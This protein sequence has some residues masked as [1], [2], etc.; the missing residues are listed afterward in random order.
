MKL[1][2]MNAIGNKQRLLK[3]QGFNL[4]DLYRGQGLN[5]RRLFERI[6]PLSTEST[7]FFS[8]LYRPGPRALTC[9]GVSSHRAPADT[10]KCREQ[11]QLAA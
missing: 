8:R 4:I 2:G 5:S 7:V 3:P 6:A 11:Y 1:L 9:H 10:D